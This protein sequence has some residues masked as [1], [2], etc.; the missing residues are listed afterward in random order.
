MKSGVVAGSLDLRLDAELLEVPVNWPME[1]VAL[2]LF[3]G[4]VS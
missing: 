3:L 1:T 2:R 4:V